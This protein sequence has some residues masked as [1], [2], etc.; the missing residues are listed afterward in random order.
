VIPMKA[1]GIVL[2]F[3][4]IALIVT[5]TTTSAFGDASQPTAA[6]AIS[7]PGGAIVTWGPAPEAPDYYEVYGINGTS[8]HSVDIVPSDAPPSTGIV[9]A[10]PEYAVVAVT[11]GVP[12]PPTLA[13]TMVESCLRVELE[14]PAVSYGCNPSTP[15]RAELEL[16]LP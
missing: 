16:D 14:P 15:S 12:S 7:Q 1:R 4:T 3:A 13:V 10:F 2:I 9:P 5:S 6:I 11:N 8:W